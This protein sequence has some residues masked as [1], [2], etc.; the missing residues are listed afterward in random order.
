MMEG[1]LSLL[2]ERLDYSRERAKALNEKDLER[3][4]RIKELRE[5]LAPLRHQLQYLASYRCSLYREPHFRAS[6][7]E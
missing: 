4:K 1:R 6:E 7:F 3:E 5:I 2:Q